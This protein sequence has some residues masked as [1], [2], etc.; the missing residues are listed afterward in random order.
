[1]NTKRNVGI[2]LL[3]IL[4]IFLIVL[5]HSAHSLSAQS[6]MPDFT[7]ASSHPQQFLISVFLTFGVLGNN[8]FFICSAWFMTAYDK[9]DK[10]KAFR[11][12]VEIWMISVSIFLISFFVG[13]SKLQGQNYVS[14]FFPTIF[15]NNWYLTCYLLFSAILPCL[16][17]IIKHLSRRNHFRISLGLFFLYFLISYLIYGK[18]YVSELIVWIAMY[19]IIA[20][21]KLYHFDFCES[22]KQNIIC[23]M[24]GIVG[25]IGLMLLTNILGLRVASISSLVLHWNSYASPFLFLTA[26]SMLNIFRKCSGGVREQ[27]AVLYFFQVCPCIFTCFMRT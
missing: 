3:K 4:A 16:N 18:L 19:F 27:R 10:K 5:F 21:I 6:G 22:I 26:F 20:Y 9:Y 15:G 24:V 1:M 25:H 2:D 11:M 12:L 13:S 7:S 17:E 8:I 14:F 23:F